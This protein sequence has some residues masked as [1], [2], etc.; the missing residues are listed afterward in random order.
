MR[1]MDALIDPRTRRATGVVIGITGEWGSGKSSI[2]NLLS[3]AIKDRH[4]DALVVR[5]DP[6]LISGRN[7]LISAFITE[8]LSTIKGE[9][10]MAS[11]I[12]GAVQTLAKYGEHLAPVG[13]L[14]IPF[15]GPAVKAFGGMWNTIKKN[16]E[17]LSSL[18]SQLTL[19]LSAIPV[20]IVV[21]IDEVDRIE[22]EEIRA[23]AQLVRSVADFPGISY[24]LAYDP[25]RVIQALGAG[26]A[27]EHQE[28]RGRLYLEKIVQLQ[29]P[30]P[31]TFHEEVVRMLTA[32]LEALQADLELPLRFREVERFQKIS[33]I[34]ARNLV[35]TPR[36]I[37]RLVG[38]YHVLGGMLRGEV[39]WI[40]LLAY[41]S[42][43]IKA[44]GT[45]AAIRSQPDEFSEEI[46][47]EAGL[48][49]RAS[50]EKGTV[51]ERLRALIPPSEYSDDVALVL[52]F[53]FPHLD[54]KTIA[55]DD[56][57]PSALYH[58]RPLLTTLRLGLLPGTRSKGEIQS[59]LKASASQ[60]EAEMRSAY[61]D[62]TISDLIDRIDDLYAT[63]ENFD[64]VQ[65]W[66]GVKDFVAKPDCEWLRAY[67]PMHSVVR[68]LSEILEHAVARQ[69][70]LAPVALKVFE[71]LRS[72]NERELT[73]CWIRTHIFAYGL[74]GREERQSKSKKVFMDAKEAEAWMSTM[75]AEW[76]PLHLAGKLIPCGWSLMPVYTMLDS[77][78]W[79]SQCR[80]LVDNAIADDAALEGLT[81][82]LYGAHYSTERQTVDRICSL[83]LYLSRVKQRYAKKDELHETVRVAL[84]KALDGGW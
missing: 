13:A 82:L 36:D 23:V 53:L 48:I 61:K 47:S 60:V 38:T 35:S 70:Q 27:G 12:G 80:Q 46:L 57:R 8:V 76:K 62:D 34:L 5:F 79:D 66:N 19:Q 6:W 1:L 40:D 65:F 84:K 30:L 75:T 24:V 14:W 37:A 9:P 50:R 4:T 39:D 55:D 7:D 63:T 72:V 20:P 43:V 69:Q 67:S 78:A 2:L 74:T 64:H 28:E 15:L 17:S 49:R 26:V 83:E 21:L 73:A 41:C 71:A 25:R 11:R 77:G 68:S 29:L 42:L 32:E 3:E 22:D 59:L 45:V 54:K 16:K 51:E 44:P 33:G 10:G 31:I 18:R 81:L 56:A 52:R 58:R